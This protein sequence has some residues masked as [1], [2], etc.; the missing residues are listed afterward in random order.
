MTVIR[1]QLKRV[2][3]HI[4]LIHRSRQILLESQT[5]IFFA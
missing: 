2:N 4:I 1:R 3:R 5:L